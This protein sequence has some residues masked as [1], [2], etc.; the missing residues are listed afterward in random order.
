[1]QYVA[2]KF[3]SLRDFEHFI[4]WLVANKLASQ[5]CGIEE[6]AFL[7]D[8][9]EWIGM[10]DICIRQTG[11]VPPIGMETR[12]YLEIMGIKITPLEANN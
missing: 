7:I 8:R 4:E 9:F 1:M 11:K 2:F 5:R 12:L 10:M 3:G 6:P